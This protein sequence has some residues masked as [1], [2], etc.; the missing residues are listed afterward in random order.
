VRAAVASALGSLTA[1]GSEFDPWFA[2]R[3]LE[4]LAAAC[5]AAATRGP[6][7]RA[8]APH[9]AHAAQ[10]LGAAA[11]VR[12]RAGVAL[13][14]VDRETHLRTHD[15]SEAL[16]GPAAF[17][18]AY[19]EGEQLGSADA[20]GL[21]ERTASATLASVPGRRHRPGRVSGDVRR[22]GRGGRR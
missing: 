8:G 1:F 18:A 2:S 9:A 6:G 19:A 7:R 16:L 12:G 20:V 5:A 22:A 11:A 10:L 14:R 15:A 4:Q 13:L 17:A 3:A 21:A